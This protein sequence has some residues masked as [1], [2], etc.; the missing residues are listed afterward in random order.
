MLRTPYQIKFTVSGITK[1]LKCNGFSYK[2]PKADPEKHAGFIK[3]YKQLFNTF[4]ED[5]P[6]KFGDGVLRQW[7][8]K[9]FTDESVKEKSMIR[10]LRQG[11][12]EHG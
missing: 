1:W 4:L 10:L 8:L 12:Q 11:L 6:I 2:K 9:S 7:L 3:E 5:E